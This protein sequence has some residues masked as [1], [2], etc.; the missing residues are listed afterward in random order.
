MYGES[1]SMRPAPTSIMLVGREQRTSS[2]RS[3]GEVMC[4]SSHGQGA[5]TRAAKRMPSMKRVMT[6]ALVAAAMLTAPLVRADP[7]PHKPDPGKHFCPGGGTVDQDVPARAIVRRHPLRGRRLLARHQP[8]RP[9]D[10]I[11]G[12]GAVRQAAAAARHLRRAAAHHARTGAARQLPVRRCCWS[13]WCPRQDSNLRPSA[14]EADAL[15]PELRG[16]TR[17]MLRQRATTD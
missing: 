12:G 8:G 13:G 7:D 14:P 9:W 11:S 6:V 16:R 15:S 17:E 4:A 5:T 1:P 2:R 10:G 3:C